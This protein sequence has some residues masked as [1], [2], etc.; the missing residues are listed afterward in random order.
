MINAELQPFLADWAAAWARLPTGSGAAQRRAHFETLAAE[1][2]LPTPEGVHTEVVQVPGQA[3]ASGV[4]VRIFRPA[5]HGPHPVLIYMHGGAWLQGSPETH[6]D[7][8][9]R[10]A[11]ACEHAVISVDYALAPEH[12]FPAAVHDCQAVVEWTFAQ[13]GTQGFVRDAVAVG[14]DSAGANLAAAMTLIYRGTPQRLRAQLLIYPACDFDMNRPSYREN[15]D[16]P[17]VTTASM[18]AVNAMYCPNPADLINPLAAPLHRHQPRGAAA[19]V[20][21]GGRARPAARQ[22]PGLCRGA[23]ACRRGRRSRTAGRG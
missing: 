4:R 8:S 22:R 15:A 23:A 6:W 12:P 16:G 13:A 19:G 9:S 5:S 17:I 3:G 20:D 10:I 2:R 7:I 18:P 21:R 14:G 1:M 11:A